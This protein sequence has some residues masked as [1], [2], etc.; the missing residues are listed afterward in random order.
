MRPHYAGLSASLELMRV[1][2]AGD[3]RNITVSILRSHGYEVVR[4]LSETRW[5]NNCGLALNC[6]VWQHVAILRA[7]RL[8][9]RASVHNCP[10]AGILVLLHIPRFVTPEAVLY[11]QYCR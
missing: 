5:A 7:P 9:L 8:Q 3:M 11:C 4:P 1:I 6:C 2:H 10:E